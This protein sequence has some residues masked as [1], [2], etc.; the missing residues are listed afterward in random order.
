MNIHRKFA[1]FAALLLLA[2]C[3]MAGD[4]LQ[5]EVKG[6]HFE[7]EV[8]DEHEERVKGLMYREEMAADHGMLFVFELQE[9]QAFWMRNTLIPLDIMYFD[10]EK[11]FVSAH[12]NVPTCKHGGENCPNYPSEGEAQYVLE[13]NAGVGEALALRPGDV[14]TLPKNLNGKR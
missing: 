14:I 5:V 9:P 1:S 11:R 13:L 7:I 3:P 2:G 12:Y 8:A 4:G 6:K 10:S